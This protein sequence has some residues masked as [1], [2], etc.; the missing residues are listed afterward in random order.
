MVTST[1]W[2]ISGR[3]TVTSTHKLEDCIVSLT[4]RSLREISL[5]EEKS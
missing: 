1:Y 3:L 5:V 4:P 2:Q